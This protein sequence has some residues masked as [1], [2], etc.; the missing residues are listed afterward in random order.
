MP[1]FR[2]DY[3]AL[4]VPNSQP[5][6][7]FVI[8]LKLVLAIGATAYD[9]HFSLRSSAVK[10]LY[11]AQTWVSEPE[12]KVRLTIQSL[13]T[14]LLLLLARVSVGIGARLVWTS[15]GTLLR[16][17]IHMGLHRDP[18]F[19]AKRTLLASEI[20]RRLWNSLLE[21]SVQY[22]LDTGCPVLISTDDFDTKPPG[23]FDDEDLLRDDAVQKPP[24]IFTQTSIAI[25]LRET[26][27]I[28]LAITKFLND[29]GSNGSYEDTLRLD[30]ELRSSYKILSRMLQGFASQAGGSSVPFEISALDFIMCHSLSSLHFPFFPRALRETAY[31][32]SRKVVVEM[33]LKLW[34]TVCPSTLFESQPPGSSPLSNANDLTRLTI[35][36]STFFR[37]AA[38]QA[39]FAVAA[40]LKAQ[41]QEDDSLGPVM[42][43]PDLTSIMNEVKIW[44]IHCIEAGETNVKGY[45]FISL[46]DAQVNCLTQGVPK[47][48]MPKLLV[49]AAESAQET[50]LSILERAVESDSSHGLNEMSLDKETVDMESWDFLVSHVIALVSSSV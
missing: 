7:A 22:S 14:N 9:E 2:R 34:R 38:T 47:D 32:Y 25:A 50:C 16:M 3:E 46:V 27:P 8:Q 23:N 20:R 24:N 30:A 15:A 37:I 43:R 28:R 5:D 35:C 48:D 40:E 49:Q 44:Y 33:S 6:L 39:C 4:W 45:L 11:E 1:T 18:V 17:A 42:L 19:L 31:A 21:I 29:L 13:Q 36:G 41:L 12:F 10:W 26:F